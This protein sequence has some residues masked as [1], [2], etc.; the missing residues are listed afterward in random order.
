MALKFKYSILQRFNFEALYNTFLGLQPREQIFALL[1][2]GFVVLFIVG[3]PFSLASGKLG[4]LEKEITQGREKQRQILRELERYQQLKK[5]LETVESKI[6]G[7]FDATITTTMES[8][9]EK[10]GIKDRIENIKE[11]AATPSE[12]FDEV[13]VDVRITKVTVPQ[14]VDFLYNIEQHPQLFLKVKQIQVKR[15][16]D[17]RQ[18]LD[19]SFQA[20][21]YRLQ[22]TG[23]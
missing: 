10:S 17:N 22:G 11:R 1:G 23:G 14:L 2:A 19:V 18:L 13:A 8:L 12:L 9:A 20:S 6:S 15:R 5:E 16:Y 3:L 4:S 21:T 7:G